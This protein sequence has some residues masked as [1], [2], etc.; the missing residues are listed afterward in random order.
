MPKLCA[1]TL[2]LTDLHKV[3]FKVSYTVVVYHGI[4]FSVTHQNAV[5]DPGGA[6][7]ACATPF[8][9]DPILSFLAQL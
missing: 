3:L 1:I 7:L 6:P 4:H 9:Q 2:N 5:P 8:Q